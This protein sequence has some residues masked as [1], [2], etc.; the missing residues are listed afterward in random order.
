MTSG[1]GLTVDDVRL[2][3]PGMTGGDPLSVYQDLLPPAPWGTSTRTSGGSSKSGGSAK[4]QKDYIGDLL[5]EAEHKQ[6]LVGLSEQE[7]RR[8]ELLYD[9][10]KRDLDVTDSRIEKILATE[11]ATRRAIDAEQKREQM[12]TLCSVISSLRYIK[13]K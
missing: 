6:K 9:L 11:E 7:A 13:L 4:V 10:K 2:P 3:T 5:K 1:R 8:A 12:M